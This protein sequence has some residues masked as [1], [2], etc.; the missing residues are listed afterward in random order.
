MY[1]FWVSNCSTWEKKKSSISTPWS[2]GLRE[3]FLMVR[4]C[5]FMTLF[6]HRGRIFFFQFLSSALP[7]FLLLSPEIQPFK[8]CQANQSG[9]W[10]YCFCHT[11]ND[12]LLAYLCWCTSICSYDYTF[13]LPSSTDERIAWYRWRERAKFSL[14]IRGQYCCQYFAY[15]A[16]HPRDNKYLL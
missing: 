1:S 13:T 9:G 16:C 6:L 12:L 2:W 10:L 4:K 5:M 15:N 11:E 3:V 14:I 8:I 7:Q